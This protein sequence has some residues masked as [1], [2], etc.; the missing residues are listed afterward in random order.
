MIAVMV[1]VRLGCNWL[2]LP[3]RVAKRQFG[4][5]NNERAARLTIGIPLYSYGNTVGGDKLTDVNSFHIAA[6]RGSVLKR[7]TQRMPNTYYLADSTNLVGKRY[8]LIGE[9]V[10]FDHQPAYVVQFIK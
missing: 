8:R 6:L 5:L 1:V 3:G 7:S 9:L 10:L 2:V 4:Q